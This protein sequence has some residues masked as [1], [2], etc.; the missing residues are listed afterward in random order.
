MIS[1]S[2][3]DASGTQIR[4]LLPSAT[5]PMAP[6]NDRAALRLCRVVE[7]PHFAR[8]ARS[9][10]RLTGPSAD[11]RAFCRY[12]IDSR[13]GFAPGFANIGLGA[14]TR[15]ISRYVVHVSFHS[16][17]FA[18]LPARDFGPGVDAQ[19]LL[20]HTF[21]HAH[22]VGYATEKRIWRQAPTWDTY[23][24]KEDKVRI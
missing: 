11:S 20:R 6:R 10:L 19:A 21:V 2:C 9:R 1:R 7:C 17:T 23:L 22:G 14:F 8:I 15:P 12:S 3:G 4:P 18:F 24:A 13:V 16:L 5:F